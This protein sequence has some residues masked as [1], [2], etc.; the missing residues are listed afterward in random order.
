M[1][2][3]ADEAC[4]TVATHIE[5]L[6]FTDHLRRIALTEVDVLISSFYLVSLAFNAQS[7]S[8]RCRSCNIET[9]CQSFKVAAKTPTENS[10][11]AVRAHPPAK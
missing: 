2:G 8:E 3:L 11:P 1:R 4:Y 6:T 9:K 10:Y 5:G 7:L